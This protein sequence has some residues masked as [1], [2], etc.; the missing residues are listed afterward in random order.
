MIALLTFS[1]HT[2]TVMD[3]T[4]TS[5][6]IQKKIEGLKVL[7]VDDQPEVRI[8]VRDMLA[9]CGIART[10]EASN[11][12]EAMQFMDT[13]F[14]T[15]SMVICD[16]NMPKMSG[17]DFLRQIR[18]VYPDLPFLMVTGQADKNSVLEAKLA[19]VSAFIRKPFSPE[20]LEN[21]IKTLVLA[22]EHA[23]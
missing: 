1:L 21:K 3:A 20:Q 7:I 8:M 13:D 10:F 5:K 16:W 6:F 2:K 23:D 12:H 4:K 18:T 9:D 19:G 14:E 22:Q 15:V 11:G 17:I